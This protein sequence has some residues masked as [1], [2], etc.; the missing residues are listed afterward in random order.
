MTM[1]S[2]GWRSRMPQANRSTNGSRKFPMKNLVF[3]KTLAGLPATRSLG[4]PTNTV[5]CQE[6]M[7]PVSSSSNQSGSH[8]GS[9]SL[10]LMLAICRLTWR[11]PLFAASRRSSATAPSGVSGSMGTP[12]SRSGAVRRRC[13]KF[14]QPVVVD[15]VARHAQHRI[16]GRN[17]EDRAE[18]DLRLDPVAVH[19]GEPQ[20]GDRRPPRALIVDFGAIEGVV[21]RL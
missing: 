10:G 2:F 15:A 6:R 14:Q 16:L 9:S 11:T 3:S 8:A 1:R 4:F 21:K 12:I 19:V 20:L 7:I 13:A 17:L 5:M 18:D